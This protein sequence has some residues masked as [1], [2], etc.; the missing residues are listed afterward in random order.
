ME[1]SNSVR[2]AVAVF[3]L[4]LSV[5]LSAPQAFAIET[6]FEIYPGDTCVKLGGGANITRNEL[7]GIA[8][9][10]PTSS[11][12]VSCPVPNLV[13]ANGKSDWEIGSVLIETT[14]R[15]PGDTIANDIRCSLLQ[16]KRIVLNS[17]AEFVINVR[18]TSSASN[19]LQTLTIPNLAGNPIGRRSANFI[20]CLIPRQTSNGAFSE[21]HSYG[22]FEV[23]N[24]MLQVMLPPDAQEVEAGKTQ[25]MRVEQALNTEKEDPEWSQRAVTS[26]TQLF[27]KEDRKEE[28][29]GIQLDN[30]ECRTTLC[31]LKLTLTAPPQGDAVFE[32][33][34]AKLI[35]L[36]P[37]PFE[38][39]GKIE[40]PDGQA[41]VA[42]F[43]I[44]REGHS[45]LNFP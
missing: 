24:E 14:D 17:G 37:W 25:E 44:A 33:D 29:T 13:N 41:P 39:F 20:K 45:L 18:G 10:N 15:N 26:W 12:F 1:T 16:V 28:L 35:L 32:Q 42:V 31:R 34:F 19:N 30:I 38:G 40:N 36:A 5:A 3:V 22:V 9:Q 6:N 4:G 7:G 8:N 21:L 11:L 2:Y 23:S 43:Y 27:Q